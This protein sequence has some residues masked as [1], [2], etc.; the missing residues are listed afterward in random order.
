MAKRPGFRKEPTHYRLKFEEHPDL[1]GFEVT[2]RAL[3]LKDF[4]EINKLALTVETAKPEEQAEQADLLFRRFSEKLVDWNLI[5]DADEPVPA[6]FKGVQEQELPFIQTIIGVWMEAMSGVPKS[7][8]NGSKDSA[9][10]LEQSIPME[11]L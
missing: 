8:Q 5:D 2:M 1:E 7:S 11:A 3:P 10:L 6:D 9:T 4:L